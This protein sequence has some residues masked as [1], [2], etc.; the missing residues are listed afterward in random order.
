MTS[1]KLETMIDRESLLVR[2]DVEI[3]HPLGAVAYTRTRIPSASASGEHVG[4]RTS[5]REAGIAD[6][7][8]AR[9]EN[10]RRAQ[11]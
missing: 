2:E 5:A 6:A 4:E 1:P 9:V 8:V 3:L 7:T 10:D 11:V